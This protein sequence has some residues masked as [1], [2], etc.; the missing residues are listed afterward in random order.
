VT[1]SLG[2]K[3]D[4]MSVSVKPTTLVG[5]K[6]YA[7][8][9]KKADGLSHQAALD[10]AAQAAD[11]QNFRHAQRK[12]PVGDGR[13]ERVKPHT[14][15]RLY[16]TA[17]WR[18]RASGVRGRETLSVDLS[19]DWMQ[20]I[21]PS[22]F[23]NDRTLGGFRVVAPDHFESSSHA[24]SQSSARRRICAAVRTLHFIEATGLQPAKGYGRVFTGGVSVSGVPGRDHAS[25]WYQPATKRYVF[26]NEPYEAA[27]RS[28]AAEREAWAKENGIEVA[29]PGWAGMYNPDGGSQLYL[30]SQAGRGVSLA[31]VVAKLN[32]LPP[33]MV[34]AGWN[35]TS[36]AAQPIFVSPRQGE[37]VRPTPVRSD[38]EGSP[39]DQ[40]R[41]GMHWGRK[42]LVLAL[43]HLVDQ[44][45]LSLSGTGGERGHCEA[46]IA[47]RRSMILWE[48]IGFQEQRLSV[49][50]DYDHSRHPQANLQ[51]NSREEFRTGQPLAK[52]H[53]YR[54][55]VGA[56]VSGWVE[57]ERGPYLQGRGRKGLFDLYLR[58]DAKSV[59]E[60]VKNPVPRG[61]ST[62]G[63]FMM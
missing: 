50:W 24:D 5:I 37:P 52:R 32:Q 16:L 49:W 36:A 12:L 40:G 46:E 44:K 25:V 6:R 8:Q 3:E 31:D 4:V 57:R 19:V 47:G 20:L 26:V 55:F 29:R 38:L 34:E 51:G 43:N 23:A 58:Q 35:G 39:A 13:K 54:E 27:A 15:H 1:F 17:Y 60:A 33:P 22:K 53:R 30:F 41:R 61:F 42:L 28:R 10:R 7:K 14:A 11:F 63:K 48:D 18:D 9:I 2:S 45:H 56:T 59:I 62:E 21:K